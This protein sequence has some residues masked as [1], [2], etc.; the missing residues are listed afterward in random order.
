LV[1]VSVQQTPSPPT[2]ITE[3]NSMTNSNIAPRAAR[4]N[5][6]AL[7]VRVGTAAGHDYDEALIAIAAFGDAAGAGERGQHIDVF[8]PTTNTYFFMSVMTSWTALGNAA[9]ARTSRGNADIGVGQ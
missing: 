1:A 9:G 3:E 5:R 6:V 2:A 8:C 4:R 7:G